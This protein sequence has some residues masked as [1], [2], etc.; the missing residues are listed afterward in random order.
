MPFCFFVFSI[1]RKA[2]IW[3]HHKVSLSSNASKRFF[4]MVIRAWSKIL[5]CCCMYG[6]RGVVPCWC[7]HTE[8]GSYG[9]RVF[10]PVPASL[11]CMPLPGPTPAWNKLALLFPMANQAVA[12]G[13]FGY[14][15]LPIHS[16]LKPS[17]KISLR[18]LFRK[19]RL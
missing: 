14:P 7:P 6:D 4:L 3:M 9:N 17:S 15:G 2:V 8:L 16:F 13:V 18:F 11:G 19:R 5:R 10:S 12:K 1:I